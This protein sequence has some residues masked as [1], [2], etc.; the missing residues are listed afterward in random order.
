VARHIF[1]DLLV[2]ADEDG[3]VDKTPEAIARNTNVPLDVVL[4]G[5]SALS[6]P[7]P[8]SRTKTEAGRRIVLID[9][10][11]DW[12]W[13][14]VNYDLYRCMRD[15][16]AR[17]IANR[18]YKRE[19]RERERQAAGHTKAVGAA[20]TQQRSRRRENDQERLRARA[21]EGLFVPQ[22]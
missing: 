20:T 12:G 11:R 15:E 2:L 5:L 7:D 18:S 4:Y 14:I 16:E 1:M 17:R 8:K 19:Q 9:E 3:V 22:S 13:R 6:R 10:G 21:R